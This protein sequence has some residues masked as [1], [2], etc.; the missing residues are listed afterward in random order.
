MT[1]VSDRLYQLGGVP[2]GADRLALLGGR[3][4]FV[5]PS[6]GSDY[7]TGQSPDQAW[8][9][10]EQAYAALRDGKNDVLV[11]IPGT[12]G[13]TLQAKAPWAK[14]YAHFVGL[15]APT[16]VG[17]RSRIF[18]LSTLTAGSP[19]FTVSGDGCEFHNLYIFQGVNDAT[20][21]INVSVSGSRNYF[22][23]VHFA[24]G[25]HTAQAI[26]GGASLHIN[27]GS[28]NLFE[29]CTIG[30]D[31]VAAAS[32]MAGLVFAATG[33]AARNVFRR[34]KF[35]MYAGAAG[36]L[37]V[38]MLG[39]SGIDR[40]QLFEDCKFINLGTTMTAA[41]GIAAGYDPANKR[42]LLDEK[43]KLIGATDW[44]AANTGM[45]YLAGGTITGG[46]NAGLFAATN[47]T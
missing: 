3:W 18:Q 27:G 33:G 20:S 11:Y 28:E 8:A 26:D 16:M 25:G 7:N 12:S 37:F 32:G 44:E 42:F 13:L 30:V 43:C 14:S 38:R 24:G 4:F 2:V 36:A 39:N 6:L 9:S 46:G 34:S 45:I 19:L 29:D 1:M 41:F 47:V 15:G 23:R 17:T 40:Y 22:N 35:T 5:D 31:T 21:L 10:Y